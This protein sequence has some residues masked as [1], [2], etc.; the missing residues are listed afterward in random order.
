MSK[1]RKLDLANKNDRPDP[2]CLVA[3]RLTPTVRG[4]Q[5][6]FYRDERYDI[7]KFKADPSTGRKLWWHGTHGCED[8]VRLKKH[9]D[10]WWCE[11]SAFP[12]L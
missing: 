11:V 4:R 12:S 10:I 9:Y 3:L 6:T 5:A 8:P 7:G 2:D 1:W